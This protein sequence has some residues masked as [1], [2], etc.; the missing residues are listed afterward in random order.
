MGEEFQ[1]PT[2]ELGDQVLL[3]TLTLAHFTLLHAQSAGFHQYSSIAVLKRQLRA[4]F[5]HMH[6]H[7]QSARISSIFKHCSAHTHEVVSV[8]HQM[9]DAEYTCTVQAD[10]T[11]DGHSEQDSAHT[12]EVSSAPQILRG[13]RLTVRPKDLLPHSERSG[14]S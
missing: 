11:S 2:F 3:K 4:H 7:A 13:V 8:R 6:L 9:T 12:H 14:H 10:R 1:R 5:I